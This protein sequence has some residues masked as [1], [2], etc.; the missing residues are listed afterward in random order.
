MWIG[1]CTFLAS[2]G[3]PIQHPAYLLPTIYIPK[4]IGRQ[5]GGS[6]SHIFGSA[7]DTD[8]IADLVH[9]GVVEEYPQSGER[10]RGKDNARTVY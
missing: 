1:S 8:A 10:I 3:I 9:D 4:P 7:S 6:G 5:L 2:N